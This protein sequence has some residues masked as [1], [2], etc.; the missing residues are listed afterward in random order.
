MVICP[1]IVGGTLQGPHAW[2]PL[3]IYED[4]I[5][6]AKHEFLLHV[7]HL[8]REKQP[9]S[10]SF[11]RRLL[12][13]MDVAEQSGG[14][15]KPAPSLWQVRRGSPKEVMCKLRSEGGREEER[16]DANSLRSV[17]TVC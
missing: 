8:I 17:R 1:L 12:R 9:G 15:W 16:E 6:I 3:I 14:L 10:L 2:E 4:T 5:Q 11:W 13:E 7:R